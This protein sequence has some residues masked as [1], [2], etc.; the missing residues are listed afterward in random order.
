MTSAMGSG[1]IVVGQQH[2]SKLKSMS[3]AEVQLRKATD[4]S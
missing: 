2:L 3:N 4:E 1:N